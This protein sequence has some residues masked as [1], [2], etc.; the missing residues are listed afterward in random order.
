MMPA[1]VWWTIA[2]LSMVGMFAACVIV[3]AVGLR[4]LEN[5][6]ARRRQRLPE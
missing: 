5:A 3:V 2:I 4:V 1:A 6:L